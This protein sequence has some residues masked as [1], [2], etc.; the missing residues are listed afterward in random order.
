MEKLLLLLGGLCLPSFDRSI[1][2]L[3]LL[4][5]LTRRLPSCAA[6]ALRPATKANSSE[7]IFKTARYARWSSKK[8]QL[9]LAPNKKCRFGDKECIT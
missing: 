1:I 4:Y 9:K 2:E 8:L 3:V 7:F 5:F 6:P